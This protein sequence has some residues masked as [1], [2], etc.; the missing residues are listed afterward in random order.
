MKIQSICS[1]SAKPAVVK[2]DTAAFGDNINIL[3]WEQDLHFCSV[4]FKISTDP[5]DYLLHPVPI[6]YS[7]LPNRNGF[8]FSLAELLKWNVLM[9][10]QAYRTWTGM[11]MFQEHKSDNPETS[12]G[13]VV[14]TAMRKIS[15]FADGRIWKVMAL[16]AIDRNKNPKLAERM[17]KGEINTYSMGAMVDYCTCSFCHKKIGECNH[18]PAEKEDETP[19]VV[20]YEK[21]GQLVFKY[22]HG[23]RGYELSSVSDPAFS[24]AIG[25]DLMQY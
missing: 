20:F 2:A 3:N 23:I 8:G 1:S 14:D 15:N 13:V 5:K 24:T 9:G 11:P 10:R 25:G 16:A 18:I 21:A 4:P 22:A 19:P 12:I 17:E 6:F 7:D